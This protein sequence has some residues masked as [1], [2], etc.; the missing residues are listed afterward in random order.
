MQGLFARNPEKLPQSH[1]ARAISDISQL[2]DCDLVIIAVSDDAIASVAAALPFEGKLVAHTSGSR[3]LGDIGGKNFAASFYPLQTFS[4]A[5]T[6]DY[7]AVPVCIEAS[8]E[9]DYAL[10]ELAASV[11]GACQRTDSKQRRAMHLSAVFACNFANHMYALAD[12]LC[13]EHNVPFSML[14]PLILETA[15]KV[16]SMAPCEAQTG[17]AIR[18][19][20]K[21]ISAH[22]EMLTEERIRSLYAEI[23]QSIRYESEKL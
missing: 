22:L 19:D 17:P 13:T 3:P 14:R 10:L 11:F 16:Q 4:R 8:R 20:A 18:G 21:T 5:R 9:S 7:G 12:S 6:P 15:L 2:A 23:T 1:R